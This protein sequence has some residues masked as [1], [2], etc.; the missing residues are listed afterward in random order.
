MFTGLVQ[1]LGRVEAMSLH[2][3]GARLEV[4]AAW[5]A[6]PDVGDSICV[7]GCCLTLAE[8][9]GE[10][11]GGVR[12]AFDVIHETLQKT[13]LGG[14]T[15][16]S[17]VNLETSCTP[18]T[19]LGGHIV[20]G[21]VEGV[22][23]FDRVQTGDDWR[24]TVRPP[25]DLMPYITPKGSITIDGVSLTVAEVDVAGGTFGVALIPTTLEATTLGEA[26]AGGRCNLETDILARTVLHYTRHY[27]RA[28]ASDVGPAADGS[29]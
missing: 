17:A 7:S 29:G 9:V 13:A 20:Q 8:P 4:G 12:M 3:S 14:L 6:R 28:A 23:A 21:H 16:G 22:G 15:A 26:K 24:I 1:A 27:A 25:A 11:P 19:L 10:A 5:D 2:A 18:T